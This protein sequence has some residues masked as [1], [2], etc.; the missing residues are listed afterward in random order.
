MARFPFL[1]RVGSRVSGASAKPDVL[2]FS[3]LRWDFVYQ[4]PH[5]LL[6]RAGRDRRVF[7]VEEAVFDGARAFLEVTDRPGGIR[8]AVPHLLGGT[9]PEE[10]DRSIASMID[11]LLLTQGVEEYVV[12]YYSPMALGFS[13]HLEP[14]ATVY[15]V[16]DE[17]SLFRGAPAAMVEREEEL[18]ARAD[19]VFTG[20]VSLYEAK[21]NRHPNV[22]LFPSS[23]DAQHFEA[24]RRPVAEPADQA[25]LPRP[26]V[27]FFGV[28]DERM[29][30]ELLAA[31]ADSRPEVQIVMVGPVVKIDP[32]D[33]PVRPNIH[34]LGP[35]S[36]TDLPR[37]IAGWNVALM[38]W[39]LNDA[40]RFISPTKTPEYLAAGKNVVSTAVRDVIDPYG[41]EALVK[42][43]GSTREFVQAIDEALTQTDDERNQW[44]KRVDAHLATTSWDRTWASMDAEISAVLAGR[45]AVSAPATFH[46]SAR[47]DLSHV[48]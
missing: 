39:A 20:G 16:M 26:R 7:F 44:L 30:L 46:E 47:G 23:I 5:H 3:H 34:Y 28:I 14:R 38:P 42:I 15:D 35:R 27:G 32:A 21:K 1:D 22:H 13:R 19:V 2:C 31:I 40:T 25:G 9:P 36:Y 48:S 45:Q 18:F 11:E 29:D 33:L 17:L 24:A 10:I 8:V 4:R 43:A 12:W 37:Y 6:T 41:V